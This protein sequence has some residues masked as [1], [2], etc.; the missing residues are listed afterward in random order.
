MPCI[1]GYKNLLC[2]ST[3]QHKAAVSGIPSSKVESRSSAVWRS[4]LQPGRPCCLAF[5]H[6]TDHDWFL[7]PAADEAW[8]PWTFTRQLLPM[9]G[10]LSKVACSILQIVCS[11]LQIVHPVLSMLQKA[12]RNLFLRSSLDLWERAT[13]L[14]NGKNPALPMLWKTSENFQSLSE[15]LQAPG[16]RFGE[17]YKW[18]WE[19]GPV[20]PAAAL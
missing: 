16:T 3:T 7:A 2:G 18:P 14:Q 17:R 12:F 8:L 9:P 15:A 11:T 13:Y 19:E 1:W 4:I 10:L 5:H 20:Q 6:P